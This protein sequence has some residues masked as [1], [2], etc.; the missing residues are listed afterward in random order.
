MESTPQAAQM[1]GGGGAT[2]GK[3]APVGQLWATAEAAKER[4]EKWKGRLAGSPCFQQGK[5]KGQGVAQ[6]R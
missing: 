2:V 1:V 4:N 5:C 6:R 3:W